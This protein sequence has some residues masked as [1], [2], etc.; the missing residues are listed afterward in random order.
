MVIERSWIQLPLEALTLFFQKENGSTKRNDF[1]ALLF[2]FIKVLLEFYFMKGIAIFALICGLILLS[3]CTQ[4]AAQQSTATL[5]P[6]NVSTAAPPPTT[7]PQGSANVKT[8]T[9]ANFAFSPSTI[10]VK[11]GDTV[12]WENNDSAPHQIASDSFNSDALAKG[13]TFQHKF[14]TK[15]TYPYHCAIHPSMTGEIIVE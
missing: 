8:I 9:I 5:P 12:T 15:G 4:Q 6:T 2:T 7:A 11:A 13:A 14:D 3:G 1:A 10:T